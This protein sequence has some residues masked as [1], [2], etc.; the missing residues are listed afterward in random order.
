MSTNRLADFTDQELVILEQA[1]TELA[2]AVKENTS[3]PLTVRAYHD[4]QF[5]ISYESTKRFITANPKG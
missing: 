4:L 3:D 5:E 1:M 2:H